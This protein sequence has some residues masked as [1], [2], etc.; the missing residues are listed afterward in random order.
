MRLRFIFLFLQSV[1]AAAKVESVV[2][3]STDSA[4]A[5]TAGTVIDDELPP[6]LLLLVV[7]FLLLMEFF[8]DFPS[9]RGQRDK[10]SMLDLIL[11]LIDFDL[12]E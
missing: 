9:R 6:P 8:V 12:N 5:A 3:V 7:E 11:I 2:L 1:L 4:E 10:L